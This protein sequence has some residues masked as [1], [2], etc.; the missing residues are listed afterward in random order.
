M[1]NWALVRFTV[2]YSS[3]Q[4]ANMRN[5]IACLHWLSLLLH[6]CAFPCAALADVPSAERSTLVDLYSSTNGPSWSAKGNWMSGDPCSNRWDGVG[7]DT[8][9]DVDHVT[10]L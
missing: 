9:G 4:T 5:D 1:R 7:C 2:P 6:V 3:T 10:S 8:D